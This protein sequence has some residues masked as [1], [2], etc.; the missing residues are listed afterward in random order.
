MQQSCNRKMMKNN[1]S[2]F[3]GVRYVSQICKWEARAFM[4]GKTF[5]FGCYADSSEAAYVRDQAMLQLHG[6]DAPLN[7]EL[8]AE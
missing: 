2:G 4:H 6:A 3:I 8:E 1:T 5:N 7:F